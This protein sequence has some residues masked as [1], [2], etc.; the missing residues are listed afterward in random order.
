ML[1]AEDEEN[2]RLVLKTLL[3]KHGYEVE[4]AESAERA[5]EGLGAFDPDF[6]IADVRMPG[7]SG[8]ELCRELGARALGVRD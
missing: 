7:M 5:L 3:K 1:V 6:V 4:T 2:L 8:I